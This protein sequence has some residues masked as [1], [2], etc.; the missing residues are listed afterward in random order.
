MADDKP[1]EGILLVPKG[2]GPF[3]AIVLSHGLGGSAQGFLNRAKEW[4]A[5]GYVCI[6]TDYTHAGKGKARNFDNGASPENVRRAVRLVDVLC[7]LDKVNDERIFLYGFS[8]GALLTVATL[9]EIPDRICAAAIIAGGIQQNPERLYPS[10]EQ[11][12]RIRTPLLMVHGLADTRVLPQ[13]SA[14]LAAILEKNGVPYERLTLEGADHTGSLRSTEADEAVVSWFSRYALSR[15]A[16]PVNTTVAQRAPAQAPQRPK[17]PGREPVTEFLDPNT[18]AGP[19][20]QYEVFFSPT[21]RKNASYTIYL[22]PGYDK[23]M[24]KHYPVIYWLHGRGGNQR[25]AATMVSFID[26]A[27]RKGT[28]PP[29]I[30][31]GINGLSFGS[32]VDKF[33]GSQPVQSVIMDLVLFVDTTYRAIGTRESRAIEGFS[34]GGAGAAKIGFKYPEIFGVVSIFAGALHDL[35]TYR[36]L[37][38][39]SPFKETYGSDD[40]YFQSNS[41]WEL[42]LKNQDAIRGRTHVRIVVGEDD[43]LYAKNQAFHELLSRCGIEH[44]Y[45][46]VPGVAHQN[47]MLC[48]LVADKTAAF[49]SKAFKDL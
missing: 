48:E 23:E 15:P 34:M 21:L 17:P 37:A 38:G 19:L 44:E 24:K 25:D 29:V 49:Y 31:V 5:R 22:P 8:M 43:G 42:V 27:I 45:I 11:A 9:A 14:D 12:E 4:Q 33:D 28:M 46:H 47:R 16:T 18:T 6:A 10:F 2:L 13:T 36:G 30:V 35:E 26:P 41:P 3:P 20:M 40:A 1:L 7:S 32:F 39:G